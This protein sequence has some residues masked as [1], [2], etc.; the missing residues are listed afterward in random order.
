MSSVLDFFGVRGVCRFLGL[1]APVRSFVSVNVLFHAIIMGSIALS[2]CVQSSI[3]VGQCA[4]LLCY[5][6]QVQKLEDSPCCCTP[7]KRGET[8]MEV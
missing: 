6:L 4:R 8:S 7:S 3:E 1:E 2:W 5:K